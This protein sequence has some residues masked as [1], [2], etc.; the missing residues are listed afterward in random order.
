MKHIKTVKYVPQSQRIK[1][2]DNNNATIAF[3]V[4]EVAGATVL[5]VGLLMLLILAFVM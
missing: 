1:Q 3:I 2:L 5:L 4:K